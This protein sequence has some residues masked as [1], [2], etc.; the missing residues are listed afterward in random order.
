MRTIR[1]LLACCSL[2]FFART[3]MTEEGFYDIS[4]TTISGSAQSMGEYRGKVVLVVNVA[5]QCGF[6]PQYAGLQKLYETYRERGLVVLGF[7]CNDF[8][9]QEPGSDA[10]IQGF[11]KSKFG[12][13]FP[14]FSKVSVLGS[15]RAPLYTFLIKSSGGTEV[16]WNFEKFLIDRSG[17]VAGRFGSNV[18]PSDPEL[19]SAIER[20]L[21]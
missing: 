18:K 21:G 5:S 6:T 15:G 9:G 2:L 20:A 10:E 17:R 16:G 3:A 12:V 7:P 11:C 13:T 4:A 19:S 8:G 1:A 14:L